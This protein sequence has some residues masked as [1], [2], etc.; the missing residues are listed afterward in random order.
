MPFQ[1]CLGGGNHRQDNDFA[2]RLQRLGLGDGMDKWWREFKSWFNEPG[3][4][5]VM[6]P[7]MALVLQFT[8]I[9]KDDPYSYQQGDSEGWQEARSREASDYKD[10]MNDIRSEAVEDY[11][12]SLRK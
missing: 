6:I 11:K 10:M 5:V 3:F 4:Y 12:R 2:L 8:G 7:L 9:V 1:R